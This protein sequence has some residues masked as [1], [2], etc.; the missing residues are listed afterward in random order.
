[1]NVYEV[2]IACVKD[3]KDCATMRFETQ[4]EVDAIPPQIPRYLKG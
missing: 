4:F 2:P 3:R 1:M